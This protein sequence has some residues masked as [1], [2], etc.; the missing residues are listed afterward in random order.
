MRTFTLPRVYV[1]LDGRLLDLPVDGSTAA[2]LARAVAE[3]CNGWA[4]TYF[5]S[6]GA[7]ELDREALRTMVLRCEA[8]LRVALDAWRIAS[9]DAEHV[10]CDDLRCSRLAGHA[11]ACVAL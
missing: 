4:R 3:T 7:P 8:D 6:L 2:A 9:W 5:R 10:D 1:T 11:G